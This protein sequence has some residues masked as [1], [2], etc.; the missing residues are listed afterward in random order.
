MAPSKI[1]KAIGVVKDQT[2]IS[3]AKMASHYDAQ[4][5]ILILKATTHE[6]RVPNIK[7][8]NEI[9]HLISSSR[10]LVKE[11]VSLICKRIEKTHDWIVALKSLILVHR[12]IVDGGRIF[13]KE[14]ACANTSCK[15]LSNLCYFKD[16]SH[17][18]SWDYTEFVRRY[19]MYLVKKVELMV[20]D[21]MWLRRKVSSS[22]DLKRL[23]E[24]ERKMEGTH[25]RDE[26]LLERVLSRMERLQRLLQRVLC[27]RS[28]CVNKRRKIVILAL[29]P[30]VEESFDLYC[31][32]CEGLSFLSDRFWGMEYLNSVKT[33]GTYATV[34]KQFDDLAEFYVWCKGVE[35]ASLEDYPKVEHIISDDL[36]R[37]MENFVKKKA[38]E[39]KSS[40]NSTLNNSPIASK[41]LESSADGVKLHDQDPNAIVEALGNSN[42]ISEA[43]SAKE[44]GE[45]L[46]L[47]LYHEDQTYIGNNPWEDFSDNADQS[48]ITSAWETPVA[49][50]LSNVNWE[51]ALVASCTSNLTIEKVDF[52]DSFDAFRLNG[53]YDQSVVRQLSGYGSASS[54][55]LPWPEKRESAVLALPSTE[56]SAEM[57]NQDPFTSS[58]T[59]PPPTYVQISEMEKK[60]QL[61][62]EEQKIWQQ[63]EADGKQGQLSSLMHNESTDSAAVP[64]N[65]KAH[66]SS[67][68]DLG[69]L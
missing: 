60:F 14:I 9:M 29:T 64:Q 23:E 25:L 62:L 33:Y 15:M 44:K 30:V 66:E 11:C 5:D 52:G 26:L 17:S 48:Q 56:E 54:L 32:I 7:Y 18:N 55:A 12:L 19:G 40:K 4:L 45:N 63:Y 3:L 37:S 34:A 36:L 41:T 27:I 10:E 65:M 47:A 16:E 43:S 67:T 58:V 59:V 57:V 31:D 42:V 68:N 13:V 39:L 28:R 51:L 46:A 61:L 69:L 20:F 2:S 38:N 22:D 6:N 1:R 53:M 8:S 35:V 49:A 50:D 24:K 21:E